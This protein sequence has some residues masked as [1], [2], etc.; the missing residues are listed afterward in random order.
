MVEGEFTEVEGDGMQS[1]TMVP[2]SMFGP[3]EKIHIYIRDTSVPG[4]AFAQRGRGE[5]AWVPWN[6]ASLYYKYSLPAHAGILRD[7]IT[8][9]APERQLKANAHPL[10]EISVMKQGARMLVHLVNVSGH[11]QTGYFPP[12]PMQD[13]RLDLAG[14]AASARAVRGSRDLPVRSSAGRTQ[15]ILPSLRDYELIVLEPR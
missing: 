7:L 12:L 5:V 3:P 8:R 13:I 14:E 4:V 11:S 9:L 1:L 15:L 6:L 2:P 10:V